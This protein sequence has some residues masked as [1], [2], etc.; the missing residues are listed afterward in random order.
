Q[1]RWNLLSGA[2]DW[3]DDSNLIMSYYYTQTRP[4]HNNRERGYK[5]Q[6]GKT[7]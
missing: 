4:L 1:P 6:R 2:A 3:G 5:N 7:I